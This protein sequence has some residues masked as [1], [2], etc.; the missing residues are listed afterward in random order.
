[1]NDKIDREQKMAFDDVRERYRVAHLRYYE[2]MGR[3]AAAGKSGTI[4]PSLN[5]EWGEV[6]T[7]LQE[8]EAAISKMVD[9][10]L[11]SR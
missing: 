2:F 8:A 7:E 9:N 4:P 5:D 11:G 10:I 6:C 3:V 1:M